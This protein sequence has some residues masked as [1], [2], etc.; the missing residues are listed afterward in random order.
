MSR[1][2]LVATEDIGTEALLIHERIFSFPSLT[3]QQTST[4]QRNRAYAVVHIYYAWHQKTVSFNLSWTQS[5]GRMYFFG[6]WLW[7]AQLLPPHPFTTLIVIGAGAAPKSFPWTGVPQ[8]HGWWNPWRDTQGTRWRQ[9]DL[10]ANLRWFLWMC[11]NYQCASIHLFPIGFPWD[12]Q[13]CMVCLPTYIWLIFRDQTKLEGFL[14][15]VRPMD[16][17][18]GIG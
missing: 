8:S 1:K 12:C 15:T 18:Y 13:G 14:H 5:S 6:M 10:R 2:R 16:R 17:S 3:S 9:L 11:A 4:P 7:A